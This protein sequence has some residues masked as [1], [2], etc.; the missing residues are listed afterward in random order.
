MDVG[1]LI[2]LIDLEFYKMF[3]YYGVSCLSVSL[4]SAFI[5]LSYR[6]FNALLSALMK[7]C[8]SLNLSF[9]IYHFL[10][11]SEAVKLVYY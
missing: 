1:F 9:S 3:F 7:S 4:L 6:P 2:T 10:R 5:R 8:V 11:C